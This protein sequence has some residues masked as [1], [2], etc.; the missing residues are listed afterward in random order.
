MR[1]GAPFLVA[2]ALRRS[3]Q[4]PGG[5]VVWA[6]AVAAVLLSGTVLFLIP[7]SP[8]AAGAASVGYLVA[9]LSPTPSEATIARLGSEIWTWPGVD[10]VTFRFPGE[11]DPVPIA[12]RA[13]LV[14]LHTPEVR[15]VVESRLRALTE[16]VGVQYHQQMAGRTRVPSVSRIGALVALV[17]TLSLAVWIG[18]RVTSQAVVAWGRELALLRSCGASPAMQRVPFLALGALIGLTG[19]GLYIGVCW[20]L[21]TWGR[22]LSYLRDVVP[23]FP[24]VWGGLVVWGAAIA[25]GLG[26]V[27]SIIVALA[28]PSHS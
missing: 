1:Y 18:Y 16:I 22:S 9:Q 17:A 2:D 14:R 21:W 6:L 23:S 7:A 28:P 27:G 4:R 26:L 15:S 5:L 12:Q 10:A 25:V 24:H 11:S 20:S 13:L 3:A 8:D 19:G